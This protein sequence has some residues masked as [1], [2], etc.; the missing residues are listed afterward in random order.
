MDPQFLETA[1]KDHHVGN[2]WAAVK[3]LKLNPHNKDA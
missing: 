1:I 3:K 2:Y